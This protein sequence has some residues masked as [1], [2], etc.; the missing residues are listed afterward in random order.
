VNAKIITFRGI[1]ERAD[2]LRL[3]DEPEFIHNLNLQAE[4]D[5]KP[6]NAHF[7]A[8]FVFAA[9]SQCD[10]TLLLRVLSTS[11]FGIQRYT[12]KRLQNQRVDLIRKPDEHEIFARTLRAHYLAQEQLL[13]ERLGYMGLSVTRRWTNDYPNGAGDLPSPPE[14]VISDPDLPDLEKLF[15][16][17]DPRPK[18]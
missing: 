1:F 16:I 9:E 14:F 8:I 5:V 15:S 2:V 17:P 10:D 6:F 4:R 11:V 3:L 13:H 12:T 18:E 7:L